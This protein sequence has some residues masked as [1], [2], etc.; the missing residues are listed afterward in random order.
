MPPVLLAALWAAQASAQP[1]D[2]AAPKVG[3]QNRLTATG[4]VQANDLLM[5]SPG[6]AWYPEADAATGAQ[7]TAVVVM[8]LTPEGQV[9]KARIV[10]STQAAA[11]DQ[12]ALRLASQLQWMGARKAPPQASLRVLFSRDS[13][14]SVQKKSCAELNQDVA[15]LKT[16]WPAQPPENVGALRLVRSLVSFNTSWMPDRRDREAGQPVRDALFLASRRTIEGCAAQPDKRLKDVFNHLLHE[17]STGRETAPPS[18]VAVADDAGPLPRSILHTK[19]DEPVSLGS[20]AVTRA[21]ADY[22]QD[23]LR[24]G[25]QGEVEV[26]AELDDAG[27][28]E[29]VLITRDHSGASTLANAAQDVLRRRWAEV[30][31]GKNAPATLPVAVVMTVEFRRDDTDSV[32][33]L[34]CATYR[35]DAA[36]WRGRRLQLPDFQ[37]LNDVLGMRAIGLISSKGR[38]PRRDTMM[39]TDKDRLAEMEALDKAC[40]AAPQKLAIDALVDVIDAMPAPR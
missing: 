18:P 36:A 21:E 19:R 10:Q 7:G 26:R 4:L 13:M 23:A 12:Q 25:A 5:L 3:Y 28:I 15:W 29:R 30:R 20:M 37:S 2:Q 27:M 33:S 22:P 34:D 8:D 38:Q 32:T 31:S 14:D 40:D 39:F 11:L 1:V 35:L 24:A 16:H 9:A 6:A 17:A